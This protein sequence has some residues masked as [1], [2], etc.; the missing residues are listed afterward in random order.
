MSTVGEL[1]VRVSR[2]TAV[3]WGNPIEDGFGKKTYDAPIEILCRWEN[4]QMLIRGLDEKGNTFDYNSVV[5]VIQDL[6]VEGVLFL[7]T[8]DDVESEALVDPF[9]QDG[10]SVIKQFERIPS[11]YSSTDIVRRAFLTQ[12][13]YR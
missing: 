1:M 6:D 3:Y 13:R 9:V 11:L 8:L 2:Q 7:G 4:K 12:W 5:Y 10:V